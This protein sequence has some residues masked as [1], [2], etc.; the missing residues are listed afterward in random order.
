ME[1]SSIDLSFSQRD[2]L[3]R[4]YGLHWVAICVRLSP[5]ISFTL[6]GDAENFL[7]DSVVEM[8][9]FLVTLLREFYIS[10]ADHHPQIRR[11]R[12]GLM[13]P[14]VLGEEYKGTQLPLK[15]SAIRSK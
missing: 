12:S 11:A 14:L 1:V 8:Q 13:V 3:R 7:S 4:R 2:I 5:S 10:Q 15:I 9:I 6:L